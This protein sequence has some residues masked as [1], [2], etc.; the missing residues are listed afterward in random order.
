MKWLGVSPATYYGI[1]KQCFT[2]A[3]IK[4]EVTDGREHVDEPVDPGRVIQYPEH[5]Y[6]V[7]SHSFILRY[8]DKIKLCV[9]GCY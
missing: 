2:T 8:I 1:S 5:F 4:D 6:I 3:Q 9:K 7:S